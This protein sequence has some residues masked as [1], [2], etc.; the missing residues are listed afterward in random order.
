M[1]HAL[2]GY[3]GKLANGGDMLTPIILASPLGIRL[4]RSTRKKSYVSC[5][6]YSMI[7]V[8]AAPKLACQRLLRLIERR[9]GHWLAI[10]AEAAKINLSERTE[11]K[12][13][14]DRLCLAHESEL[15]L[16]KTI[17]GNRFDPCL[18]KFSGA[19]CH[20]G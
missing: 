1:P 12:L 13:N 6:I 19:N 3:G 10:Q 7:L 2:L 18:T 16:Q 4:I 17:K 9:D 20:G 11:T 15:G 8:T 14:L 5:K